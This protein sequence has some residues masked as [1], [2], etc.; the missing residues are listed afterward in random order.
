MGLWNKNT[1]LTRGTLSQTTKSH[2]RVW[3]AESRVDDD[4]KYANYMA[5]HVII[6]RQAHTKASPNTTTSTPPGNVIIF[7]RRAHFLPPKAFIH[8]LFSPIRPAH[9]LFFLFF[10]FWLNPP[11]WRWKHCLCVLIIFHHTVFYVFKHPPSVKFAR[12][13]FFHRGLADVTSSCNVWWKMREV[14]T[15]WH[16]QLC[17]SLLKWKLHRK[18]AFR[19]LWKISTKL[20]RII[21]IITNYTRIIVYF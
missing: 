12:R 15:L 11:Q 7:P 1:A 9:E 5:F 14:C 18:K 4:G 10:F 6:H 13:T 20:T 16:W 8:P 3:G 21:R 19:R 17:N 2:F